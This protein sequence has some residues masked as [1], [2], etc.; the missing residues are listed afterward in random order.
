[1]SEAL[2]RGRAQSEARLGEPLPITAWPDLPTRVVLCRDDRLLR[3]LFF[4]A[5]SVSVWASP[6]T[7]SMVVAPLRSAGPKSWRNA[8]DAY[9][10]SLGLAGH[11]GDTAHGTRSVAAA[12][13][14]VAQ[15]V[16]GDPD[17]ATG[18]RQQEDHGGP[19]PDG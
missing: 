6:R 13:P 3:R 7:S 18:H 8:Y 15:P 16:A 11:Q 9:A 4:G 17:R 19:D 10:A 5:S 2:K 12:H 14:Q 1:M